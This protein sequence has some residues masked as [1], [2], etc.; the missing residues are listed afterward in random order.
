MK[1]NVLFRAL[2]LCA[3]FMMRRSSQIVF[4]HWFGGLV[5]VAGEQRLT[6]FVSRDTRAAR[7]ARRSLCMA[8]VW[9]G[10]SKSVAA[11]LQS[12]ADNLLGSQ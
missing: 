1:R 2:S 5:Q 6:M 8:Q 11:G 9:S 4:K 7:R 12:D 10:V 3:S